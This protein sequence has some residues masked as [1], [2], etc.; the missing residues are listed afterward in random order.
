MADKITDNKRIVR[1][2]IE[3]VVNTGD[4]ELMPNYVSPGLYRSFPG[5]DLS[6]GY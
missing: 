6:D 3:K 4:V 5:Q 1:E 2:Y